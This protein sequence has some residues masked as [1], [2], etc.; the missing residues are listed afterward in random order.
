[1]RITHL[2]LALA[3]IM[4][5]VACGDEDTP[6]KGGSS[7]RTVNT[8]MLNHVVNN[9]TGEVLV[10]TTTNK[11]TF[12]TA[13]HTASLELNYSDGSTVHTISAP[14]LTANP[15][16]LGF[17]KLSM[18]SQNSQLTDL[19]GYIDFNES[20]M[21]YAYTTSSGYRVISTLKEVYYLSTNTVLTYSDSTASTTSEGTMYQFTINPT[22]MTA[23]V[24]VMMILDAQDH[25]Y[26]ESITGRDV[27]VTA[28]ATGYTV[29][30][31]NIETTAIYRAY[32]SSTGSSTK[33]SNK[34]PFTT[35][36][37]TLNLETETLEASYVLAGKVTAKASGQ[38]YS[39]Y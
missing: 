2:L 6:G 8:T 20:A 33:T 7:E 9:A 39:K 14:N 31:T 18:P 1:M 30:G 15:S 17:Y 27:P 4:G 34:Y 19:S 21:R 26:F 3:L 5:M 24:Q 28:T 23:T 38:T 13:A 32:D 10:A 29:H 37:A 25:K 35:F 12:D 16:R 11:L 22:T 36:D